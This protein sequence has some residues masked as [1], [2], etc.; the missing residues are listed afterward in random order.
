[1]HIHET[2]LIKMIIETMIDYEIKHLHMHTQSHREPKIYKCTESDNIYKWL[3]PYTSV[4]TNVMQSH[5]YIQIH[6]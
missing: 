5:V 4:H 1:M 3:N 2:Q 6:T